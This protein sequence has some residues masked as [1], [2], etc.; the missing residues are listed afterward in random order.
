MHSPASSMCCFQIFRVQQC[1]AA[2]TA[3]S[4]LDYKQMWKPVFYDMNF[5]AVP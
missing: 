3:V 1:N 4:R 5:T 2:E